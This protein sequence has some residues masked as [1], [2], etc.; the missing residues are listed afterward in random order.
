MSLGEWKEIHITCLAYYHE[1]FVRC[2]K[3]RFRWVPE[4][5]IRVEVQTLHPDHLELN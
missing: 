3:L 5:I 1:F 2:P 4:Q